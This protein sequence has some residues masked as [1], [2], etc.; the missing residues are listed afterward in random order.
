MTKS[1]YTRESGIGE[2]LHVAL[3][4]CCDS[5]ITTVAWNVIHL[6][7]VNPAWE[8]FLENVYKRKDEIISNP[9]DPNLWLILKEAAGE[10]SGTTSGHVILQYMFKLF[11]QSDWEGMATF[12]VEVLNED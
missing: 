9:E 1:K 4:K 5:D 12:L 3:R 7:E 11:S 2:A 8:C 6:E 10:I